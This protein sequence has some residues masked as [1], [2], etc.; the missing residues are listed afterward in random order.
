MDRIIIEGGKPLN[1]YVDISGS[2]NSALPCLFAALLTDEKCVL[3]NVP[4]L[5]DIQTT[6]LLLTH[7][8]KKVERSGDQVIIS[9]NDSLRTEAPYELVRKMRASALVL[10]PLLART[11]KAAASLP[12][13][14]AIGVRP[15]NIHLEAFEKLG[16]VCELKEGIVHLEAP[17]LRGKKIRF[18][19]PSVGA[20]ENILMASVLIKGETVI[21]NA[22]REP[23]IVDLANFLNEMGADVKGAGS[24]RIRIKGKQKLNGAEHTVIPDRIEAMT[25]LLAAAA[26][27]GSVTAGNVQSKHFLDVISK[28]KKAGMKIEIGKD[29]KQPGL[30]SI[31]CSVP[32]GLKPVSV[33]TKPYPDFPT[34]VQA[35]WMALMC[36]VKGQSVIEETVFENRFLH[37]AEL[38]RMGAN[39]EI[40]GKK[41]V[42]RGVPHLSGANVMVSDLRAGAAMI[43]A[44]LAA[45]GKTTVHRIYHLDRGY[46]KL[47]IK[48]KKLGATIERA[49]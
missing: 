40:R 28:M 12:G 8:G 1:G 23:E 30:E 15:I 25:Y 10:G 7:L 5:V 27:G 18:S 38:L 32:K 39:I 31:K 9:Q 49:H 29:P 19:F 20:T 42:I 4:D 6:C 45:K 3:R 13:G 41:A 26:T 2:K 22:A 33:K 16:A 44:G 37:A 34:D 43:I 36:L 24:S 21:E 46:E 14:C 47:E 17:R 48:L 35:Q 11:G